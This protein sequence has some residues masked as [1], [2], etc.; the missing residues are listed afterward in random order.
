MSENEEGRESVSHGTLLGAW[1]RERRSTMGLTQEEVIGRMGPDVPENYITNL[2]TGQRKRMI[3]QPRL[4]QLVRAL[5]STE[6]EALQA[7]G[8]LP[9]T[10]PAIAEATPPY[11]AS[12][13]EDALRRVYP[14]LSEEEIRFVARI[15]ANIQDQGRREQQ[16]TRR[17]VERGVG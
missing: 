13:P 1:V 17:G 2:E 4:G 15:A 10:T 16:R 3:G 8:L 7:S 12:S 14:D 6:A 11:D 9:E 5:A